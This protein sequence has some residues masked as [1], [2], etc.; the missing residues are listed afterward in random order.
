MKLE[1][2]LEESSLK[3]ISETFFCIRI[4]INF[5][6][7][8]VSKPGSDGHTFCVV[9]RKTGLKPPMALLNTTYLSTAVK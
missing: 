6:Q 2:F 9:V 1:T 3:F 5:Q 4:K 8:N 7:Q